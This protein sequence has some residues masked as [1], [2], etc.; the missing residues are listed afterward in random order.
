MQ[1]PSGG[2][3]RLH[4]GSQTAIECDFAALPAID[5]GSPDR[6]PP[7]RPSTPPPHSPRRRPPPSFTPRTIDRVST[8]AA[9]AIGSLITILAA[10]LV[11][12]AMVPGEIRAHDRRAHDRDDDLAQWIA[13]RDLFLRRELH[14]TRE[15]L[16][17]E[18]LL[19]G[20]T[21]ALRVG[22]VKE[23]AL[24]EWRDEERLAHRDVAALYDREGPLHRFRRAWPTRTP[25]RQLA[26]PAPAQR[27]L[28]AWRTPPSNSQ[29]RSGKSL[30]FDDPTQRVFTRALADAPTRIAEYQ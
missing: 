23:R 7:A 8:I 26:T 21:Y 1:G 2:L 9:G 17:T 28:D 27:I 5:T 19:D 11:R 3:A 22:L 4:D 10:L 30:P 25:R 12:L 6:A 18:N 24:H 29:G 15:Q 14:A 20:G 16:N 13:D